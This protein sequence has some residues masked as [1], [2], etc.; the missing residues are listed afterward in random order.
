MLIANTFNA[1]NP[2]SLKVD[3]FKYTPENTLK[4]KTGK[5]GYPKIATGGS[6]GFDLRADL[7]N[8]I[9]ILPQETCLVAT[10][11]SIELPPNLCA[12]VLPRSGLAYKHSITVAN[13]PGLID[14]DYRGEICVLLRNEGNEK[15]TV[16]DGD[17]IAQLLFVPFVIPSFISVD[18]LSQT[19]RNIGGF[20]STGKA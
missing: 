9:T 7:L 19:T 4:I 18:E 11:C 20:G 6:A 13:T 8:N 15:F 14:P 2:T 1:A 5:H 16:E 3:T 10:G 17:R 12:L